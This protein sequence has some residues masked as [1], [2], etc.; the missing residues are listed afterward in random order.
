[1]SSH[2]RIRGLRGPVVPVDNSL[3]H[4]VP[5][6]TEVDIAVPREVS[7]AVGVVQDQGHWGCEIYKGIRAVSS[8][9]VL[10]Q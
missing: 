10:K 9:S 8:E 6:P 5:D 1:M 4:S 2:Q 7:T 3:C